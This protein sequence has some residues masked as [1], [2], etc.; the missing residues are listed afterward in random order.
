[1]RL[2]PY[3]VNSCLSGIALAQY[4][5]SHV[6]VCRWQSPFAKLVTLYHSHHLPGPCSD[7]VVMMQL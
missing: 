6:V 2:E 1:M 5:H 4:R 7:D 3:L